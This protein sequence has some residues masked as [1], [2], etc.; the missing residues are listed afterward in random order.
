MPK[1]P[2]F[3]AEGT[4]T[5][6]AGVTK[7][8]V[9]IPLTQTIGAA[10]AP[11]TKTVAEHAVKEKNFENRTEALKLENDALLELV[12][13]F[14]EAAKLDNKEQA[15]EIVKNKSEIIKNN[16]A[17]KASNNF[18]KTA[19]NNNFYG[20]VQKGIF[21]VNS[22]VSKNIIDSLNVQVTKKKNSILTSA[23]TEK[24]DYAI[25]IAKSELENLYETT[26]KGRID[27]DEYNALIE[28][29]PVELEIYKA[30]QDL[31]DNPRQTYLDLWDDNKYK[32]LPLK[33]RQNLIANAKGLL[34]PEIKREWENFSAAA[35]DGKEIP[36][37]MD[38]A[39]EV[40]EPKVFNGMM[41]QYS[42]IKKTVANTKILNSVNQSELKFTLDSMNKDAEN[43]MEYIEF[44]KVKQ[45]YEGVVDRRNAAMIEDPASFI[46]NTNPIA[47]NL[48]KESQEEGIVPELAIQRKLTLTQ[49]LVDEQKRLGNQDHQIRVMSNQETNGFVSR[50]KQANAKERI[51][52]LQKLD[53]EFGEYNSKA[54]LELSSKG[55]PF[56]AQL[57]SF[58]QDE[59]ET[60]KFLSLDDKSE[61]Q[62]LRKFLEDNESSLSEVRKVV[63][64]KIKDFEDVIVRGNRFD[65]SA[66]SVKMEK[67]VETLSYYAA[68]ELF[69][70]QAESVEDAAQIAAGLIMNRFEVEES[71]YVPKIFNGKKVN[72]DQP[73][74]IIDKAEL[75]KNHYLDQ[76]E[77]VAFGSE[78][79]DDVQILSE[80]FKIQAR[81]NGEWRNTADGTGLIYGIVFPDGSFTPLVNKNKE[82]LMFRFDDTSKILPGTNIEMD[83]SLTKEKPEQFTDEE[84]EKIKRFK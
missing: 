11:L 56:T 82:N 5:Q 68:N 66:A 60:M 34:I 33:E 32:N 3:Q 13:V 29:I 37:D 70:N 77:P 84:I 83:F 35:L 8:G 51:F 18:V 15:F 25:A 72:Y 27:V 67:I 38:F 49:F 45:Y 75:I 65:T 76:F 7:T 17:N 30:N 50:Y 42:I 10:L 71:Y 48:L 9:S 79:E 57:S 4:I 20:E 62:T 59:T 22:R 78:K 81:Y 64:T 63:R 19:F 14:D 74:G 1:I 28:N 40:L 73:T 53:L 21:K 54:L 69:A 24:N 43:S 16:Y 12:D 26:L 36:F 52:M 47:E 46:I 55:L 2:T 41:E 23:F 61:Q 58:L 39:K 6:E 31:R 44:K 80:E